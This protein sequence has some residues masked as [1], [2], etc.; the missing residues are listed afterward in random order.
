[1]FYRIAIVSLLL[2]VSTA[3]A[4]P[5]GIYDF[6]TS[7][8][9]DVSVI[10]D[11]VP[12]VLPGGTAP[13]IRRNINGAFYEDANAFGTSAIG[14]NL[15]RAGLVT[16]S[17][18]GDNQFAFWL[19]KDS[20]SE[21]T[22][23]SLLFWVNRRDMNN[24]DYLFY[25]GVSDGH[26]GGSA[27]TYVYASAS[28]TLIAENFPTTTPARDM[29]IQGGYVGAGTWHQIGLVREGAAFSMF[30]D[31]E[32]IGSDPSTVFN[33][34]DVVSNTFI[35][36]GGVKSGTNYYRLLD[37]MLDQVEVYDEALTQGQI[38]ARYDAIAAV[39]EAS[40]LA[41]LASVGLAFG[42]YLRRRKA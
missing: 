40:S 17:T 42:I 8:P 33:S 23:W 31:G 18:T 34:F 15:G 14:T 6:S 16:E 4:G 25:V 28:G 5:I 10:A 20:V 35:V 3:Q 7:Y 32:L 19:R 38:Q 41:L 2:G 37:G 27:E 24:D 1:M 12:N 30:L 39:P 21:L 13:P 26:S 29:V 11:Y 36:L 9:S 22:D